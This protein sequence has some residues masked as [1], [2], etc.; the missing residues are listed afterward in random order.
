MIMLQFGMSIAM[1]TVIIGKL[2]ETNETA[3][4]SWTDAD[5]GGFSLTGVECSW[6]GSLLLICHPIGSLLSSFIQDKYGRKTCLTI[7]C[8][9]QFLGWFSLFIARSSQLLYV[10]SCSLGLAMGLSEAPILTYVG[11]STEPRLR[12]VLSSLSNFCSMIGLFLTYLLAAIISWRQLAMLYMCLPAVVFLTTILVIPESPVWLLSKNRT[13]QAIKSLC[14]L[15]GFT[16]SSS[17]RDE[18]NQ[19]LQYIQGKNSESDTSSLD[20]N[21]NKKCRV[22]GKIE[23][24]LVLLSDKSVFRPF[25]LLDFIFFFCT[26][27]SMIP[28]KPYLVYVIKKVGTP[29]EPQWALVYIGI[30]TISG[31][32]LNMLIVRMFGKRRL[33]ISSMII[34]TI[35]QFLIGIYAQYGKQYP[36]F[37]NAW[38]PFVLFCAVS[39]IAGFGITAIPWILL[40][41]LFPMRA[42]GQ[43]SGVTAAINFG[44]GFL[45]TKTY[46]D[47]VAIYTLPWTFIVYS[48]VGIIGIFYVYIYLPETENKTLQQIQK[49]FED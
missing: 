17:V 5:N 30:N 45:L 38:I 21:G 4:L 25:I 28:V 12:S 1:P 33:L 6:Y 2:K 20:E 27:C 46:F 35:L 39:F 44:V 14:W 8:F 47:V 18:I 40:G 9:P 23:D 48:S 49:H 3:K 29:F 16:S 15:R 7:V 42:R 43:I 34:S 36:C 10:S 11:E 19:M 13:T 32:F 22:F 26:I 24:I 31:A 41:E 37:Q